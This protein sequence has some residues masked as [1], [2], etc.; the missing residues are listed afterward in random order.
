MDVK[1]LIE[2]FQKLPPDMQIWGIYPGEGNE[3][4]L[5]VDDLP[6]RVSEN[7]RLYVEIY[8]TA[9]EESL[10]VWEFVTQS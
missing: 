7:N 9:L 6:F 8:D 2:L 4:H 3:L 1:E 10:S 5:S